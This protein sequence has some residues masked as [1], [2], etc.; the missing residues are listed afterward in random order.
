M[1]SLARRSFG[2]KLRCA[3]FA[4][5]SFNVMRNIKK[6]VVLIAVLA[7]ITALLWFGQFRY[8]WSPV[9]EE[10][11]F[12]GFSYATITKRLGTPGFET[13]ASRK[14]YEMEPQDDFNQLAVYEPLWGNLLLYYKDGYCVGS[15]FSARNVWF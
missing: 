3:S 6:P 1:W 10:D 12:V 11:R 7:A 4:P 8:A 5:H 13:V 14:G 15:V 2:R 9:V